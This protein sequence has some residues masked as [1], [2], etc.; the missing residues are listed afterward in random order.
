MPD[1]IAFLILIV[2]CSA[3]FI[4]GIVILSQQSRTIPEDRR[5]GKIKG[6]L[7]LCIA[8]LVL[9][10]LGVIG[11]VIVYTNKRNKGR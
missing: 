8:S 4:P 10:L 1:I 11:I 7:F 9:L 6:G 5:P 2:V 3:L